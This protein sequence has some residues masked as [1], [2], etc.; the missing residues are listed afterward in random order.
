MKLIGLTGGMGSGKSTVARIFAEAGALT[1]DADHVARSVRAPGTEAHQALLQRF[2]TADRIALRQIL[3]ES[4][5]AKR[6]LEAILHP[7]IRQASDREIAR[8]MSE[9][10]GA[11]C[12]IYEATLLIEAGRT[13]DFD[14][15]IVVTSPLS[16]RLARLMNRDQITEAQ[17]QAM[18]QSQNPDAFRLAHAD[19]VIENTVDLV[20]LTQKVRKVLDQIISA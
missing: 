1:L 19:Y 2:Q 18:I 9:T 10:P 7:L 16:D 5:E 6:D 4:P 17:A 15:L 8:L 14:Q 12:L 20:E 3:S 11:P 13:E